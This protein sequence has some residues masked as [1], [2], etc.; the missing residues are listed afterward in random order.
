M[1]ESASNGR[2]ESTSRASRV[3]KP[4]LRE[5][6]VHFLLAAALI[7]AVR[8]VIRQLAMPEIRVDRV[9]VES[10]AT[11][12]AGESGVDSESVADQAAVRQA[13][14]DELLY[15]EALRS[16]L[17]DSPAVR[18]TL[19]SLMRNQLDPVLAEP[20]DSE[21]REFMRRHAERYR[22][23]PQI[24]FEHVSFRPGTDVP[25]NLLDRLRAG[26]DPAQ[27]GERVWLANPLPSTYRPLLERVL[28]AEACERVFKLP[29][30]EWHGPVESS[31]GQ[32]FVR[33]RSRSDGEMIPFEQARPTL[34][35]NL[36]SERRERFV[37]QRVRELAA[38]YRILLP[39]EFAEFWP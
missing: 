39:V 7:V 32:H 26:A 28:G 38:R 12:L 22:F 20:S 33:V 17:A 8:H 36:L 30:G 1:T 34:L 35:A 4:L 3:L 27:F 19:A 25:A 18:D 16:G 37:R 15:R 31:R 14:T 21:L 11:R 23:P 2:R 6:L 9:M 24:S 13:V 29:V 5:P 10:A